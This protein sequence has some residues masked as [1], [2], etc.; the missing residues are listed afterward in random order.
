MQRGFTLIELVLVLAILAIV[1][2]LAVPS[3]R[4][5]ITA[6]EMTG[7]AGR[8]EVELHEARLTAIR[9]GQIQMM[10]IALGARDVTVRPWLSTDDT[11]SASAGASVMTQTG[12][13]INTTSTGATESVGVLDSS[14]WSVAESVSFE[15]AQVFTDLR[16]VVQTGT[17]TIASSTTS[18]PIFFYPDGSTSTARIVLTNARGR[19]IAVEMR[20]V[21]GAT[22]IMELV[23]GQGSAP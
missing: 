13:I 6:T 3:Y 23:P 16:S 12:Q 17:D 19:R 4:G 21:T 11:A 10:Q 8:L 15:S 14:R 20:G 22:Q 18:N 1:T 5:Y 7:S 2:S 9:T